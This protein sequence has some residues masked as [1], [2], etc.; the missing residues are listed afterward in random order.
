M[1]MGDLPE[2]KPKRS[3]Q[4]AT[5]QGFGT[6][7]HGGKRLTAEIQEF[8][9]RFI[10][11]PRYREKLKERIEA[12]Q[13][14]QME[15]LIWHYAYGKPREVQAAPA[16]LIQINM[17]GQTSSAPPQIEAKVIDVESDPENP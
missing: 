12:G 13:A 5:K 8:C 3:D 4:P 16:A 1:N 9:R 15:V 14:Q 11:S 17:P 6:G 7:A 2:N 10:S